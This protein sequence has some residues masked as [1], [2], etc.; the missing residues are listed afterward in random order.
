MQTNI[1]ENDGKYYIIEKFPEIKIFF[2]SE[3]NTGKLAYEFRKGENRSDFYSFRF[4][5]LCLS[6][7]LIG[8]FIAKING[9]FLMKRLE[10]FNKENE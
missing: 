4:K 8:K 5:N 10:K 2:H 7:T 1:Y 6:K 3:I 9:K